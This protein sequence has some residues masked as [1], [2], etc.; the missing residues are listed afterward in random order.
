MNEQKLREILEEFMLKVV[1]LL[2][3][4]TSE[5]AAPSQPD[6][7]LEPRVDTDVL[8]ELVS[9]EGIVLEAY[10]DSKGI[11]TWGIGVTDNS[12]HRVG[13]YKDKPQTLSKVL[14][15]F[16]W[17][18]RTKYLPAVE[19]AFTRPLTK[20]QLAAALSFH[21]N[22][23]GINKAS[24]V[25]SFNAGNDELARKQIM[26]WRSPPEIIPRRKAERDLFFDGE[27]SGDGIATLYTKVNKPSYSPKWSSATKV[28]IREELDK[29]A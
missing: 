25:K 1:A 23:G 10:K 8:A 15:I 21:Y 6:L 12:G 20:E 5:G 4:Y 17:L 16:E 19:R 2:E 22:T 24:W 18:V 14:E 26:N 13:R 11:W 28:N 29:W 27:W 9:H 7:P 3:E